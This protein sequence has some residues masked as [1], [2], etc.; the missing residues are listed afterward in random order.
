MKEGRVDDECAL[1]SADDAVTR[2]LPDG[3][4]CRDSQSGAGRNPDPNLSP[5]V[6]GPAM[7]SCLAA[8]PTYLR[9]ISHSESDERIIGKALREVTGKTVIYAQHP[10]RAQPA[11]GLQLSQQS[12]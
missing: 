2:A 1:A 11:E 4:N 6:R 7:T 10:Q 12:A 5:K 9:A 3:G 8:V